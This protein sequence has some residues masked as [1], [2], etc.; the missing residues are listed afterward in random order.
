MG[1]FPA[2]VATGAKSGM[3]ENKLRTAIPELPAAAVVSEGCDFAD[4]T[5]LAASLKPDLLVGNSKGAALAHQLAVPLIRTG[6]PIHD[7]IGGQRI[8]HFGYRGAQ[9]LFDEIV[10]TLMERKQDSSTIGYSY[11]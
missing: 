1:L 7:R 5:D 8:L 2:L 3:F 11:I 10:N 9:Q 6:F 4:M